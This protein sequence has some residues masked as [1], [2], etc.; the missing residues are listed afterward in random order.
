D[1][2]LRDGKTYPKFDAQR[3]GE[4]WNYYG[5]L[6]YLDYDNP[7]LMAKEGRAITKMLDRTYDY[8]SHNGG[9]TSLIGVQVLNEVDIFP[10]WRVY[11]YNILDSLTN[12]RFTPERAW[13]KV[14][15]SLDYLGKVVKNHKYKVYTR[16]NFA[17]STN[18][19]SD[20]IGHGIWNGN[21]VKNPPL[22]AQEI[23]NTE[24]IDIVGDDSYTSVIKDL[25]GISAMYG[26]N[27]NGNF[28]HIAENDGNFANTPSLILTALSQNAGYSIYELATSPFFTENATSPSIN[29]GIIEVNAEKNITYKA[30]YETTKNFISLLKKVNTPLN[31][32][33]SSNIAVFNLKS[34]SP[35]TTL[36]QTIQ[37]ENVKINFVTTNG[38]I[39]F[40]I[41]LDNKLYLGFNKDVDIS[42][43][44]VTVSA[45]KTGS[46]GYEFIL[47]E[48]LAPSL[49]LSLNGGTLYEVSFLSNGIITSTTWENIG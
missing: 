43:D 7:N 37:T 23:F 32:A 35:T 44:N 27:L 31:L 14:I 48:T 22:W 4:F 17:S 42:L 40:G 13:E 46:Y 45:I 9:F 30:H 29:Q 2:I 38:A 8:L 33:N 24:G 41:E 5:I 11:Q 1:Y 20:G 15:N 26:K 39:G 19:G 21:V 25:K 12:E 47:D 6:W 3:T 34:N 18:T 36:N 10:R 49:S 16:T 28:S